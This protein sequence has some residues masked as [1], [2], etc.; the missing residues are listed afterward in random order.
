M[1]ILKTYMDAARASGQPIPPALQNAF[2]QEL[3]GLQGQLPQMDPALR[4]QFAGLLG[5]AAQSP[6]LSPAQ[7]QFVQQQLLPNVVDLTPQGLQQAL[8]QA[9]TPEERMQ[10]LKTYMDAA[11]ASGQPIPPALQ[12]IF[13]QEL[14]GL[15]GQLPQMDPA[16]RAQF[17]GLLGQAAQS[18]ILI[19]A[20]K[21][22]VQ[23]QLLPNVVDLTPQGLQQALAQAQT[24]EERMQIDRKS[25]V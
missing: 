3:Q 18:P 1:Q 12:N 21:Q 16:L 17:A 2:A 14:Q 6:I 23:Q 22:F 7:K 9:Q 10:I 8:A 19:P 11:R 15:Q 25:V 13:A 20:Q 5:Q 4:A 24:P